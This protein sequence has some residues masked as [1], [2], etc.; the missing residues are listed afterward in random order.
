LQ[1]IGI[2]RAIALEPQ[3]VVA[4]EP[5]S[6]LDVSIRAQVINLLSDL[7]NSMGLSFL[8]ISHDMSIVEHFCDRVAVMYLG[9]IVEMG[10]NEAL[11][12]SPRHP[13]TEA[14][15]AAIPRMEAG[16]DKRR[17]TV[18][19]DLPSATNLP[20]GCAFHTRCPIKEKRCEESVPEL[21]EVAPGHS[22]ACFLR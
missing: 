9:K 2:A 19:G 21:K 20:A 6:A 5:V 17:G 7:K 10:S 22:V 16:K 15:L 12:G 8:F 11:F 14:L 13:Y 4:D 3:L 18:K 1:R